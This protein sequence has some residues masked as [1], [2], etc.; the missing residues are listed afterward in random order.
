MPTIT[1]SSE[2]VRVYECGVLYPLLSQKDEQT[3]LK[4]IEA[5]FAEV[6]ATQIAKDVWGRRGLAYPIKGQREGCYV[7]YHY[8]MDPS[9]VKEVD[10]QLRIMKNLLRHLFVIPPKGY[11][12]V[13]VSALYEEWLKTRESVDERR[14]RVK[15]EEVKEKVAK[16]A[17]MKAKR[18]TAEKKESAPMA[19]EE[20]SEKLDKLVSDDTMDL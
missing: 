8:E 5:L 1:P 4:D 14:S 20:L 19:K 13:K 17:Q 3:L 15:E 16:K 10:T 18:T 6:G 2:D 7:V 9:K 11:E 12:I